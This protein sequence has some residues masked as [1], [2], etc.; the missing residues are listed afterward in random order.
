MYDKIDKLFKF[1]LAVILLV[2]AYYLYSIMR[3]KDIS[4]F[5]KETDQKISKIIKKAGITDKD[6]VKKEQIQKS[7][8]GV[9]WIKFSKH[10]DISSSDYNVLNSKIKDILKSEAIIIKEEEYLPV[11]AKLE[12]KHKDTGVIINSLRFDLLKDKNLLAVIIDDLGRRKDAGGFLDIDLPVTYS[13]LPQRAYSKQL[14][15][16]LSETGR[17]YILH[18]PM[19]PVGYPEDD[20]GK[21]A[22]MRNMAEEEIRETMDR[23]FKQVPGA[24]GLNNHMGSAFTASR[25]DM[26]N[27]MKVLK[28]KDLFFVDSMTSTGTVGLSLAGEMDV[29]AVR[30]DFFLDNKDD[31]DY[32]MERLEKLKILAQNNKKTVAICHPRK[33]T[34]T[35][36]KDFEDDFKNS[37]FEIVPVSKILKTGGNR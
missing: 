16:K 21:L 4:R 3:V 37:E 34:L 24:G 17:S 13:I 30:N 2:S 32:I 22:L 25:P 31:Y 29:P 10:I 33:N 6:T 14:A 28:E 23:A 20:P 27:L 5:S 18:M 12:V 15:Q 26:K 9:K 36:L 8:G 1:I 19:E 7:E 11:Q 35:A